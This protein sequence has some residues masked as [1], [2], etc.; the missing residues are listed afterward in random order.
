MARRFLVAPD[1]FKGTLTAAEVA[2]AIADGL[3]GAGA[4][5][6]ECPVAD[7]GEGTI[8]ALSRVLSLELRTS[9]C[10]DPLGRPLVATWALMDGATA[11]VEMAA[12][13]GLA[14]VAEE[15]RD[16]ERASSTGTGELL[17]AAFQAGAKQSILAIGGTATSDGGA[18]ALEAIEA[19]GGLGEMT[20]ELACDVSIPYERAAEVFGPQKGATHEAVARLTRR[21]HALADGWPRDPRGLAMTGAGGGL[22]GALWSLHGARL[23]SGASFVLE[24]LGF[25]ALLERAD[26]V[27]VGEGCLDGQSRHGKIAGE[28]LDRARARSIPVHAVVGSVE[29]A[30]VEREWSALAS[31]RIAGT[32]AEL[33]RAGAELAVERG[34][35]AAA[36]G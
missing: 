3:R 26:A 25:D 16:A 31:T 1:A 36:R 28:I 21:L 34:S 12:A 10:S 5:A 15:E 19:A 13:S 8:E 22:A 17:V 7:G 2:V 30:A 27:V 35:A 23:R 4:E 24:E 29:A 20:L 9:R 33:R 32:R 6:V 18:G 14:L 11:I